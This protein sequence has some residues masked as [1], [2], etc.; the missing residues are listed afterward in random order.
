MCALWVSRT[1]FPPIK[2]KERGREITFMHSHLRD[3]MDVRCS[4][5]LLK[6]KGKKSVS[7]WTTSSLPEFASTTVVLCWLVI[8]RLN[9][10]FFRWKEHPV[11]NQKFPRKTALRQVSV[12]L[13]LK[14]VLQF[15]KSFG[16][17]FPFKQTGNLESKLISIKKKNSGFV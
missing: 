12:P 17:I 11:K 9:T 6:K 1:Q 10:F 5:H 14:E 8:I 3:G 16:F 7:P 2:M 15:L 4:M 13:Q